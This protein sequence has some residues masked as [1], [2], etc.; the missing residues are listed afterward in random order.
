MIVIADGG[1]TK[2]DWMLFDI[3]GSSRFK[4]RTQGLNPSML[5]RKQIEQRLYESQ[6]LSDF[7]RLVTEVYFYGAGCGTPKYATLLEK[8]LSEFFQNATL[9][10]VKEDLAG[11]VYSCTAEPGV[12]AILGT[13]SNCCFFNGDD[14]EVR[15]PSLGYTLMDDASGNHLG[16]LLLRAYYFEKMPSDLKEL[17][18]AGYKLK[19]AAVKKNLYKKVYPNAYLASF[20][21]FALEHK[22]HPYLREILKQAF[23][24]FIDTHLAFYKSECEQYPVHFVGSIAYHGRALLQEM[25][26]E[27]GMIS[28]KFIRRPIDGL[29]EY[30]LGTFRS[31]A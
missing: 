28:G 13:G 19:P 10:R 26:K 8:G 20:A 16:K 2:C 31:E 6:D 25:L 11:A 1:S 21:P 4:V 15:M 17:F 12:V 23:A 30:H 27:R 3:N 7:R 22:E 5:K 18:R 24:S 29:L 14:I 9:I